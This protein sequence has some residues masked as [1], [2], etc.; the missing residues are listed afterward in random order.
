MKKLKTTLL[1][2]GLFSTVFAQNIKKVDAKIEKVTVFLQQAQ[3]E[4]SVNT[5]IPAG[6]SKIIVEEIAN[7]I[8]INSIQVEGKGDFT[9]LGV[10]YSPN[11]LNNKLYAYQDSIQRL[12]A[13]IEN[14]EMLLKVAE[15][16]EK[17]I[18]ANA[19]VK[20]E[21]DGLLPE[22]LKE[23]IDFFRLKLTEVGA[24]RLQILRQIQPLKDKKTRLEK[25]L[26]EIRNISLPLGEIELTIS[27]L[28]PT[29][30]NL[31]IT[32]V[33][34]NAG[35]SPNYDLRVKDLKSP[36]S[37]A[38]KANVFQNTGVD[39]NNVKLS[40][41]TSNPSVSGQKSELYPQYLSFYVP[42][43]PYERNVKM[44]KM[45][46]VMSMAAPMAEM[47]SSANMVSVVQTSLS[48]NFDI[49]ATYTIPTGRQPE[50]V[51]IQNLQVEADY[52]SVIAPK[53]DLNAFLVAELKDWEKLHLLSGEANVYFENKF[54]G[55]TY[56]NEQ[57]V[58]NK[59]KLSIGKD[60]RIIGKREELA[61]FKARKTFGSNI[62]ES[63]GYQLSVRNTKSESVKIVLEDQIPVSQDSDIEVSIDDIQGGLIEQNTGKVTWEFDLAPAQ[64]KEVLMKYTVKY[65]KDK[66]I[67]NL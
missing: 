60:L 49:S 48:V 35:W 33:A 43:V 63:F 62:K 41:S 50:I 17:M 18:M 29:A 51:E 3:I 57:S 30:A 6:S 65:P 25:Q 66:R 36:V 52:K 26:A 55:K 22:D 12:Q 34:Y 53:L 16:E 13:D 54:I 5:T 45:D 21:K 10:K 14:L 56:I 1:L 64:N 19:N 24:R 9:L 38:Y 20:S 47:T 59:L 8:D 61:D 67:N 2:I 32:Y 40:L 44:A 39:W 7:S 37:I 27:A 11:H 4:N 15:N 46:D 23:M 28:K 42:P 58:D 31:K